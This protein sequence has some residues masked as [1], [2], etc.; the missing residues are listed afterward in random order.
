MWHFFQAVGAARVPG[1]ASKDLGAK[2]EREKE[3]ENSFHRQREASL[4][5]AY[6]LS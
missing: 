2:K 3:K 1:R 6:R 4:H 5:N